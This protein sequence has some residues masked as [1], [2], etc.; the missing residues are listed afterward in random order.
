MQTRG[1]LTPIKVFTRAPGRKI[2]EVV[3]PQLMYYAPDLLRSTDFVTCYLMFAS[4][5]VGRLSSRYSWCAPFM[6]GWYSLLLLWL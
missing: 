3:L 1:S 5:V 6:W 4:L 2:V